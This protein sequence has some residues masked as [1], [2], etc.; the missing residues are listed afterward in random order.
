MALSTT[1][2]AALPT[3]GKYTQLYT[4]STLQKY[5]K[6]SYS[7]IIFILYTF[8]FQKCFTCL[9]WAH[10]RAVQANLHFPP[11]LRHVCCTQCKQ[12]ARYLLGFFSFVLLYSFK[13]PYS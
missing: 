8:H 3:T 7:K 10:V 5:S 2:V 1:L 13:K 4:N 6:R 12:T 11:P 9:H